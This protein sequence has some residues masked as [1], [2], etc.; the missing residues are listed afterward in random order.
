MDG[1]GRRAVSWDLDIY[2]TKK[3]LDGQ[4]G[5]KLKGKKTLFPV[6]T[7]TILQKGKNC[8]RGPRFSKTTG[9]SLIT[10]VQETQGHG[11]NQA[12]V[13]LKKNWSV[14]KIPRYFQCVFHMGFFIYYEFKI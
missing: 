13:E 10:K 3:G 5:E 9:F 6:I 11:M 14:K 1:E 4:N 7:N 8:K 12:Q 2:R